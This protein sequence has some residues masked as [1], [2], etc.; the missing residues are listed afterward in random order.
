MTFIPQGILLLNVALT[1]SPNKS[2]D[3][4][5]RWF[6]VYLLKALDKPDMVYSG[7]GKYPTMVLENFIT[8]GKIL[9]APDP[10]NVRFQRELFLQISQELQTNI[11]WY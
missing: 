8:K 6:T 1:S 2:H 9:P 5:W 10:V 11:S 4:Q 7:F 3:E